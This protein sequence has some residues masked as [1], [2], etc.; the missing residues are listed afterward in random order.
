VVIALL[1]RHF[2]VEEGASNP[3]ELPEAPVMR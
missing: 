2:A 1:I 3:N